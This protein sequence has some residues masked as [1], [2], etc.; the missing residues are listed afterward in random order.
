MDSGS[1]M[2]TRARAK[3]GCSSCSLMLASG[4]GRCGQ[5]AQ[6]PPQGVTSRKHSPFKVNF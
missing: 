5:R 6:A 4:R 3:T 2:K 1:S